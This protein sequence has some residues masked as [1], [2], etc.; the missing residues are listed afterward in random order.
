MFWGR[1]MDSEGAC[2]GMWVHAC[3]VMICFVLDATLESSLLPTCLV[4]PCRPN[5]PYLASS[6]VRD[7]C[8]HPQSHHGRHYK[9][10]E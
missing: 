9:C 6:F 2:F 7:G 3:H 8:R 10:P 4:M 1:R 5:S